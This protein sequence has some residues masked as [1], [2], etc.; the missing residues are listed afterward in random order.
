MDNRGRINIAKDRYRD[1]IE[2]YKSKNL[3]LFA[4]SSFQTHSIPMLA[5]LNEIAPEIPIYFLNTGFHF[6]ETF[7]YKDQITKLLNLNTKSIS[8]SINKNQQLT[9]SGH[10]S[11]VH[12]QDHCCYM[13]KVIPMESLLNKYDVWINGIR[14]NQS[15]ERAKMNA[16][17]NASGHVIRYHPM[18]DWNEKMIWKYIYDNNIPFHPLDAEGYKSIGCE[19]CTSKSNIE[20]DRDKKRDGRWEGIEKREC[21]LHI[22]L[23]VK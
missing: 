15:T 4:S 2:F 17:E 23:V 8:S 21:G 7:R 1:K 6:I 5:L 19:P 10:F 16:E 3:R 12:D 22:N 18:L 20:I 9:S 13:N 14:K 11:Y